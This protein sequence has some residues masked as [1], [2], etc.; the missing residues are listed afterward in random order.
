VIALAV[1]GPEREAMALIS[2]ELPGWERW[3]RSTFWTL[4]ITTSLFLISVFVLVWNGA[5]I[6]HLDWNVRLLFSCNGGG[7]STIML[8]PFSLWVGFWSKRMRWLGIAVFVF[9]LMLLGVFF[10]VQQ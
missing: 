2:M 6:G 8:L 3:V 7:F 5:N 9:G 1:I 4:L 10:P